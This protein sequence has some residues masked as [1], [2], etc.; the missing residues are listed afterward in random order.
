MIKY[1]KTTKVNVIT[2]GSITYVE[3]YSMFEGWKIKYPIDSCCFS[4][5]LVKCQW[6]PKVL[7]EIDTLINIWYWNIS[8][9]EQM[10][11]NQGRTE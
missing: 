7:L 9:G 4:K 1:S 6:I 5:L 11:Y 3:K 2:I 8:G 10:S